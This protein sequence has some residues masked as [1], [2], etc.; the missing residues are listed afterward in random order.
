M[1]GRLG[2][3]RGLYFFLKY[4]ATVV[5]RPSSSLNSILLAGEV[6][7][8]R[9]LG[10]GLNDRWVTLTLLLRSIPFS[11]LIFQISRAFPPSLFT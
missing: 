10:L 5:G 7:T 6:V 2:Y 4:A 11:F 8:A 1:Q 9:T 3:L